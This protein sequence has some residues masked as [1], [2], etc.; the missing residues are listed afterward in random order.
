VW[1][2]RCGGPAVSPKTTDDTINEGEDKGRQIHGIYQLDGDTL[3]S[4]VAK[5]G[6]ERPKEFA[7]AEGSGHTLR[8]FMKVSPDDDAK[9]K[10]IREELI[11]FGGTWRFAVM[12]MEGLDFP[13]KSLEDTRLI[14]QGNRFQ[15]K[16]PRGVVPGVFK[17]DPTVAPKTIDI[18]FTDPGMKDTLLGIYELTDNTYKV[19]IG[20]PGKPRPTGFTSKPGSGN[21]FEILKR[22]D[23]T[24]R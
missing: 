7:S 4:C 5:A 17:I 1:N 16:S 24:N 22:D 18:S 9:A 15:S 12:V 14:I 19:S 23:K 3:V 20:L 10:A 8:V 13:E 21:G 11:R 6:Q 2:L